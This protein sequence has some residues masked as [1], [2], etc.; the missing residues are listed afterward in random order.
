MAGFIEFRDVPPPDRPAVE[1]DLAAFRTMAEV[2]IRL[3]GGVSRASPG[4]R[5]IARL[6]EVLR[7]AV[8][9][10][11]P[12]RISLAVRRQLA[13]KPPTGATKGDT[14]GGDDAAWKVWQALGKKTRH[15]PRR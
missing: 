6:V 14:F 13:R 2:I 5:W 7:D 3:A 8:Q 10:D 15:E 1:A 9:N 4:G 12:V 11:D